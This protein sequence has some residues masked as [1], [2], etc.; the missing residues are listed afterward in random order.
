MSELNNQNGCSD[1]CQQAIEEL[2]R[3]ID[4]ELSEDLRGMV[5]GH[6][7]Q[8]GDCQHAYEFHVELRRVIRRK[9]LT[10]DLPP[11][12]RDKLRACFGDDMLGDTANP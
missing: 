12:L 11:S 1:G 2:E 7:G 10:D 9:A 5:S 6:L 4:D 3:F 8:C